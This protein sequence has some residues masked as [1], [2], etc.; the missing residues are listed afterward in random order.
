MKSLD[1]VF[2]VK[3]ARKL[4]IKDIVFQANDKDEVLKLYS[5]KLTSHELVV[6]FLIGDW[7]SAKTSDLSYKMDCMGRSCEV[8]ISLRNRV[9]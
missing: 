9:V 3:Y 5:A 4:S 8:Q 6:L 1:E 7:H 2:G